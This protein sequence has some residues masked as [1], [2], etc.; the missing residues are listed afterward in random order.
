MK[1]VILLMLV[2]TLGSCSRSGKIPPEILSKEKMQTV[3]W[4]LMQADE[5][6]NQQVARDSTQKKRLDKIKIYQQV[7]ALNQTS[8]EE[9]RK[10]YRFYMGHPDISKVLFDSISERAARE[11]VGLYQTKTDTAL[12]KTISPRI[13]DSLSDNSKLRLSADHKLLPQAPKTVLPPSQRFR[14]RKRPPAGVR[15]SIKH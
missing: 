7:F 2:F 14:S 4:Q 9:F 15:D 11:R 12:K 1:T 5:Y 3:L 6:V 8:E 10:S 13:A